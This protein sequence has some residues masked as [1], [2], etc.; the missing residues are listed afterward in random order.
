MRCVVAVV[1]AAAAHG[2]RCALISPAG[3]PQLQLGT[4]ET[5]E[6]VLRKCAAADP[7]HG[8]RWA[9]VAKARENRH[10]GPEE[11]VKMVAAETPDP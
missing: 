4:P 6:Q 11:L 7:H 8:E 5:Q 2:E 1:A 10:K 9:A 3:A